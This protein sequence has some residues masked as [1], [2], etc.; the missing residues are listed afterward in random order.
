VSEAG[1]ACPGCGRHA[2]RRC[3]RGGV[4]DHLLSAVYVYPFRCQLCTRRFRA[5]RWGLRYARLSVDRREYERV[6]VRIP[7]SLTVRGE[8]VPAEVRDISLAGC[9][10]HTDFPLVTG[11]R[12]R[13]ELDVQHSLPIVIE[14]AT[15][16]SGTAGRVGV[17]F[18][19]IALEQR[20]RLHGL[21]LARLG[22]SPAAE[23]VP[24]KARRRAGGRRFRGSDSLL[25]L[26]VVLVAAAALLL[27]L[28]R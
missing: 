8:R 25:V 24:P 7:A 15:A 27:L 21:L 22:Y 6:Q 18:D 3:A 13:L 12:L 10:V 2:T 23:G 5:L 11:D 1:P 20:N 16:R 28:P 14:S 19:G 26:I 17:S 4:L 9:G